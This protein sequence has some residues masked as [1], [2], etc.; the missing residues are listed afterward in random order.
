MTYLQL[1]APFPSMSQPAP[2]VSHLHTPLKSPYR[3]VL[4]HLRATTRGMIGCGNS[5]KARPCWALCTKHSW[6]QPRTRP[7][8]HTLA[9][10]SCK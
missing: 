8:T 9:K 4:M 1:S 7:I 2:L 6:F 3:T 10:G 5:T